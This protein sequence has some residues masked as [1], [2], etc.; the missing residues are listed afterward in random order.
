MQQQLTEKTDE[1][2]SRKLEE[3]RD[4]AAEE[5]IGPS[6]PVRIAEDKPARGGAANPLPRRA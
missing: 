1:A 2:F 4:R 6:Y 5:Y 3:C